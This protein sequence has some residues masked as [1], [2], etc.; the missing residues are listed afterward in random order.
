MSLIN[1]EEAYG[2]LA[3]YRWQFDVLCIALAVIGG[4]LAGAVDFNNDEPQAAVIVIVVFAG[5][6]GIH[7]AEKGVAL[8]AHRRAGR[9][10]R[11]LD[12]H[13][14]GLPLQERA[15][16][17]LVCVA[18]RADSGIH[19]HLLRSAAAEGDFYRVMKPGRGL[20]QLHSQLLA[21]IIDGNDRSNTAIGKAGAS[22]T[23]LLASPHE[24]LADLRH[25][26]RDDDQR[27]DDEPI[28]PASAARC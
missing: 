18:D 19:Q 23:T 16:T 7:P 12:R 6:A 9:A 22:R 8:G 14:V 1:R 11:L 4:F 10:D 3:R 27:Q 26:R 17:R 21:H 5:T 25:R 24:E 2:H 20:A 28:V 13:C 15:R